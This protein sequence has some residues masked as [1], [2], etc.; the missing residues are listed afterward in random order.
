NHMETLA[1]ADAFLFDKT[2]TLTRGTFSVNAIHPKDISEAELLD[3]AAA[4]ESYSTH[5]VA[6]SII[7]AHG[8]H[9]DTSRISQTQ[10]L[11]GEGVKAVIDGK[12]YYVGN[13]V[14]MDSAGAQWHPCHLTGTV[15][16]ISRDAE[17][18]GHIVIN[19]Q[20]KPDS[21]Q[22][23]S[24]LKNLG[25]KKTVML[26]GDAEKAASAVAKEAGVDEYRS[27]LLPA[28]KVEAV[29]A[30]IEEGYVTA[31]AGDG[32]NDAPV[33]ARAN[34]GIAMGAMG[35]D[36]AIESADVVLMDD[37]PSKLPLALEICRKTMRIV[38]QNIAFSLGVK[39]LI[40]ILT[41]LGLTN[42]W[43]AVFGDVGV[44]LLAVLNAS[45]TMIVRRT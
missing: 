38:R 5:P 11:S 16:H 13:G 9:I 32:I 40:L 37:K 15:I 29:E 7:A 44:M 42:M 41:A 25:V 36:A 20:I 18:L 28:Q 27:Q 24:A 2:G 3:I 21:A 14:L 17:Y 19:D 33:L 30:L 1:K 8:G 43:I 34:V 31:F 12:A 35:S 4:A 23:V 6:L 45:R 22:A 26:T 39:A 10:E